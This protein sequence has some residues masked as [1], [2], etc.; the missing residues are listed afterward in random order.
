MSK[1]KVLRV[2]VSQISSYL[3]YVE[4]KISLE[5]FINSML[6]RDK[7]NIKMIAGT[8]FHCSI[9]GLPYEEDSR[10]EF[11]TNDLE[12]ARSKVDSRSSIFEYK[13]RKSYETPRGEVI[14]TGVA[15]Q[16]VGD[17]ICEFKT[18]Y[19]SFSYDRYADSVQW[20]AY[21]SLFGVEMVKYQ[22][23][24]I[25]EPEEEEKEERKVLRVKS[26]NEF[27]MYSNSCSDFLFRDSLNGAVDLI[28]ALDLVEAMSI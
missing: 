7:P 26:Y 8:I 16:I 15:D 11:D 27:T 22:V 9:Q 17:T 1:D 13:I 5:Q 25:T 24:Q 28:Y 4:G 19:S 23:W 10:I 20:K 6:R 3:S 21:C 12:E 14:V 2:S 18:T